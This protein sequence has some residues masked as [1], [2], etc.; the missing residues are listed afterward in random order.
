VIPP[1]TKTRLFG[2]GIGEPVVGGDRDRKLVAH[3]VAILDHGKMFHGQSVYGEL[4]QN[5]VQTDAP[6]DQLVADHYER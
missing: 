4:I 2:P 1:L 5:V 6:V 3:P